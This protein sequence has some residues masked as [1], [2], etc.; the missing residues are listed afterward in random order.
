[1]EELSPLFLT[2]YIR[3]LLIQAHFVSLVV[4]RTNFIDNLP[5]ELKPFAS[6]NRFI[7]NPITLI[8]RHI[9]W[10]G[11]PHSGAIFISEGQTIPTRYRPIIRFEG[12]HFSQA[13]YGFLEM[14]RT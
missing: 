9:V 2:I 3:M 1:M 14:S 8:D 5:V 6:E 11:M 13:L 7:A 10:Y 4:V 12:K